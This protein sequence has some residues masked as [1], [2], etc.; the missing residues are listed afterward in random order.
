MTGRSWP[1]EPNLDDIYERL[2]A[3]LCGGYLA[4]LA[5]AGIS[6]PSRLPSGKAIRNHFREV[7]TSAASRAQ[8]CAR[9]DWSF[10][11]SMMPERILSLSFG[12][13][14]YSTFSFMDSW[15]ERRPNVNHLNLATLVAKQRISNIVTLN[16][17]RLLETAWEQGGREPVSPATSWAH[18]QDLQKRGKPAWLHKPHDTLPSTKEVTPDINPYANIQFTIERIGTALDRS[19]VAW[20]TEVL[21][22]GPLLVT[23]Y[24]AGDVDIF[25]ALCAMRKQA[26]VDAIGPP[27]NVYWTYLDPDELRETLGLE[28]WLRSLGRAWQPLRGP[29][30]DHLTSVMRLLE[31]QEPPQGDEDANGESTSMTL[32]DLEMDTCGWLMVGALL[33]HATDHPDQHVAVKAITDYLDKA[34]EV[35]HRE[36]DYRKATMLAQ[37]KGNR[38]LEGGNI[39]EGIR[40]Y[41]DA[42]SHARSHTGNEPIAGELTPAQMRCKIAHSR[43]NPLASLSSSG[44]KEDRS[45]TISAWL[46]PPLGFL[47]LLVLA[48]G[49]RRAE[50]AA[51]RLASHFLGD[52]FY[53]LGMYSDVLCLWR[54][55]T[56][57]LYYVGHKLFRRATRRG[58]GWVPR[59]AFHF[60][61]RDETLLLL[62]RLRTRPSREAVHAANWVWW[63]ERFSHYQYLGSILHD[64]VHFAAFHGVAAVR[65]ALRARD[66]GAATPADVW[67]ELVSLGRL[68]KLRKYRAGVVR[69]QLYAWLCEPLPNAFTRQTRTNRLDKLKAIRNDPL[70]GVQELLEE[71]KAKISG[72]QVVHSNVN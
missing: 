4:V 42:I 70:T 26:A 43:M 3:D 23:G 1:P 49:C 66:V 2:A 53:T 72:A 28:P 6:M 31:F 7:I 20:F 61:R 16:F 36:V 54:P 44:N 29:L 32:G 35:Q 50:P 57:G 11:S 59:D 33:M 15:S 51:S 46:M 5:G 17:D 56:F 47:E 10:I 63:D 13:F 64:D 25:P 19:L 55:V 39:R 37:L 34:Y 40:C 52:L 41:R 12:V 60:L 65:R 58:N 30:E 71:F 69:L 38:F 68:C 48:S 24:S 62:Q 27:G 18:L 21:G 14:G 8:C 45:R 9:A 22:K 67:K